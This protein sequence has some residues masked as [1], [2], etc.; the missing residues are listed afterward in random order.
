MKKIVCIMLTL[1]MIVGLVGCKSNEY[2]PMKSDKIVETYDDEVKSII[3]KAYENWGR[4]IVDVDSIEVEQTLDKELLG[5][6]TI[7]IRFEKKDEGWG[8]GK[9][10]IYPSDSLLDNN[11]SCHC[12]DSSSLFTVERIEN[13]TI[14]QEYKTSEEF[15]VKKLEENYYVISFVW[16]DKRYINSY[17]LYNKK[18]LEEY[19]DYFET[20][21][22]EY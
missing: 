2:K 8:T 7:T 3:D 10:D 5:Y 9:K 20:L 11:L 6:G 19:Q 16:N 14:E 13:G 17:Y 4:A 18:E 15:E 21:Q 22:Y 1:F 12:K